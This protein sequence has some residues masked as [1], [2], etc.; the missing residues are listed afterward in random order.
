M[1]R[2]GVEMEGGQFRSEHSL[3]KGFKIRK[4]RECLKKERLSDMQ[5]SDV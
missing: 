2:S 1:G 3:N 5:G 4:A